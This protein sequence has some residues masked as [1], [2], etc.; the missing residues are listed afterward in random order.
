M[1][2]S[3]A[4]I[5]VALCVI[6]AVI[7]C[8]KAA[9]EVQTTAA[10]GTA[11]TVTTHGKEETSTAATAA[12]ATTAAAS[13]A[14]AAAQQKNAVSGVVIDATINFT[15]IQTEHGT[16]VSFATGD[17]SST[18]KIDKSGIKDGIVL[19]HAVRITCKDAIDEKA[20]DPSKNVVTKMEDAKSKCTDY[21]ALAAAGS[22]I[23]TVENKDIKSLASSCAYP[24]YVGLKG[25]ATVKDQA[26]F[27][28]KFTADQIFTDSLVKAVSSVNLMTIEESNAGMVLSGNGAKPDVIISST[29]DGW[30]ITGINI[31]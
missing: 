22:I 14:A 12:K 30:S 27:E 9:P 17:D 18:E 16:T 23:L 19:G 11:V 31:E 21:D 2:K 5:M 25:G 7:G 3:A 28:K 4:C 6:L 20:S 8:G 24:V 15:T 29:D 13:T 1:R 26:E 10:S